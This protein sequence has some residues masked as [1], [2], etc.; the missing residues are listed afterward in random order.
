MRPSILHATFWLA[1]M[2]AAAG[3]SPAADKRNFP[4]RVPPKR[5]SQV[6]NGFGINSDLPRAPYLPWDRWWWTRMFDAGVNWI[7]IGQY[8]NSSDYTSWDWVEQKR[9]IYAA[10]PRPNR[11]RDSARFP[12]PLVQHERRSET[13]VQSKHLFLVNAAPHEKTPTRGRHN[14]FARRT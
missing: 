5:S 8:E 10:S 6:H 7:R 9:G 4:A 12:Y 1:C 2:L 14:F 11:C 3:L 13:F